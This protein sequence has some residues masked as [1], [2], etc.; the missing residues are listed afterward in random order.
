MAYFAVFDRIA[1]AQNK[2]M[3][4]LW[5]D[6]AGRVVIVDRVYRFNW[7]VSAVTGVLLEQELRFITARAA[8]TGVQIQ[9]EDS[10]DAPTAGIACD[11]GSTSV[12]EG[13]GSRALIKRFHAPSEEVALAGAWGLA[14]I[15]GHINDAQM[16]WYRKAGSSGLVLRQ[17]QGLTIKNLTNSTIGTCSYAIEF[18]DMTA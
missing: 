10:N 17:T 5:N 1:P 7:Q 2:Y 12:T 13:A 11:T 9:T 15:A 18:R 8:G 6:A 14:H 4:T 16:V 3:A